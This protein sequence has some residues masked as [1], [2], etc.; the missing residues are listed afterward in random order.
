MLCTGK[1]RDMFLTR[2]CLR[3][4]VA[5]TLLYAFLAVMG[6]VAFMRMGRGILPPIAFP[7]VTVSAPYA[8]A[9]AV[10]MERLVI[11]PLEDQLGRLT[12]V[13][14]ISASAQDGTAQISVRFRFG[15]NLDVARASV[16]QAANAAQPN[17]PPD[18]IAPVVLGDD[19][20]RA[21]VL[22]EAVSSAVLSPA[23]LSVLAD[24]TLAPALRTAPGI[25][26]VRVA[27]AL[28]RQ[29]HVEPREDRLA[30]V[31]A[32]MLD[33]S[34]AVAGSQ[35]VLA[36]GRF[37]TSG[38][39]TP[40]G[41][42]AAA[43]SAPALAAL[44]FAVPGGPA[45][46]VGDVARVSDGFAERSTIARVDGE[47]AI[48]IGV[49]SSGDADG[50]LAIRSARRAFARL[51][52]QWGL[53][54][55]E[56]LRSDRPATDA[57][58]DGV[59]QTLSEGIALTVLVMLV[60]LRAWRDA[61]IAAIAIPSSL[62]AAFA[63]M[64]AL[65]FTMNVLSLMGLALTIGILVDDSIVVVEAISRSAARGVSGDEAALRG[66]AEIGGVAVAITLVDVVVFAPIALMSG[67]VGE[68]MRE[69]GLVVVIAT[70][71]SLFASFTLTPLL[72]ARWSH[73][74]APAPGAPKILPWTL[75]G[76]F[77]TSALAAWRR[78][79]TALG[80]AERRLTHVYA[81]RWLAAAW[82]ARKRVLALAAVLCI[83]S[84][85]PVVT[86]AIPTE[87]SPP[88]GRGEVTAD[89][90]FPAG[91]TLAH[92]DASAA[93][94]A[95]RLMD[96]PAVAHVV[97]TA[98]RSSNGSLDVFASD[99]AEI[100]VVPVDPSA[101]GAPLLARI[102]EMAAVVPDAAV[103]GAG[104]GMGGQPAL[105]FHLTGDD[106]AASA[107]AASRIAAVLQA[108]A[109]ATDVRTSSGGYG[110]RFEIDVDPAR[111]LVLGVDP[112]DA[113]QTARIAS[114]GAIAAKARVA[115]GL[116]E[117]LV[118]GRA[119]QNGDLDALRRA[120]VRAANGTRVPLSAVASIRR[121]TAPLVIDRED[122]ER[123]VTVSA[124]ARDGAPIGP[125]TASV[126]AQVRTP[127]FLPAGVRIA[128]RGDVEQF[129]DTVAR[130]GTA[131]G[132]SLVGIFAVLAIL[133][134]SYALP[135]V[136]MAT[137]PLAALGA[138]GALWAMNAAHAIGP[139]I[140]LFDAQTLNLYSML[141]IVMLVGLVA[142]NGILLVEYAERD[143]RAGAPPLAAMQSAAERRFRA[144]VMTTAAMI[145]GMTPLALGQTVG[146]EYRKALGTVV[147]GG[148][149]S[150]LLLTL[151]VVPLV[152]VAYRSRVSSPPG[153]ER[154]DG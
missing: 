116:I 140:A 20:T 99:R 51:A 123:I 79:V 11:E 98:G 110:P 95:R 93:R 40:I 101:H 121:S 151:F 57:A 52:A 141:G 150:S 142:K 113:A 118:R 109:A 31:G 149:S 38:E 132:L 55:F 54:R 154:A 30:A 96:D 128:P 59:L 19:V 138:F 23:D 24:R 2:L 153:A 66:R 136:I 97:T 8:G 131:L 17:L 9:A 3:N 114:G 65:G 16:Q 107:L 112:G 124:N 102:K 111:A 77:A 90:T 53:V 28:V 61:A 15:T 122:R 62:C 33:L 108:Q 63:T 67:I 26:G 139:G 143:V 69:F 50:A 82:R 10:E 72:A 103:A 71:F 29:L 35:V 49:T 127:G 13:E 88:V 56:E 144:I 22:E 85:G 137:V 48:V 68:F 126:A 14:R 1:R 34:R 117:V 152:Y 44:P 129:L 94:L 87:F 104:T 100:I 74:P 115:D 148:L 106:P 80:E 58:I 81:Q 25:G 5:V 83:A 6:A 133:Y 120:A 105:S 147:I 125:L 135:L 46:R 64:W 145:A 4:P 84:L 12:G 37:T 41:V 32:T 70:A 39:E 75:R 60:F 43:P 146:A 119:A 73:R 42:R 89:L 76:R 45:L 86:G 78:A 91:T 21:P 36:G 134:R 92:T 27:G 130:I 47:P 7:I 18:I